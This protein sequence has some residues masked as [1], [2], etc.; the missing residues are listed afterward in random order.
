MEKDNM[1]LVWV[2]ILHI[3]QPPHQNKQILERVVHESYEHILFLLGQYPRLNITLN[4]SGSLIELLQAHGFGHILEGIKDYSQKGRIE[5]L[6]SAMYHPILPLIP[7]AEMMR[8]IE[9]NTKLLRQTFGDTYSHKGFYVPEM[10]YSGTVGKAIKSSG[11]EWIVLDQLHSREAIDPGIRYAIEDNGLGVVFRDHAIS[12]DFPPEFVEKHFD[13]LGSLY[14]V[15]AHD[16]ELYGHWHK[17]NQGFYQK[18]FTDPRI[19][20]QTVSGYLSTLKREKTIRVRDISWETTLEDIRQNNPYPLWQDPDNQIHNALWRFA[21]KILELVQTQHS[22]PSYPKARKYLDR[23]LAS[24]MWWCA[25]SRQ[26]V[27]SSPITWNPEEVKKGL[28]E[29]IKSVRTLT[30]LPNAIKKEQEMEYNRIVALLQK[31]HLQKHVNH[32]K[33]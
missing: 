32:E 33:K 15:T 9:L 3:Y 7:E 10:A 12:R 27:P 13:T 21:T 24:C 22:D 25:S 16:G 26:P 5:L 8:Q 14:L 11:F 18:A 28:A 4:I 19:S 20:F 23:G 1:A 2:N 31:E 30:G 29:L 17:D 6:G